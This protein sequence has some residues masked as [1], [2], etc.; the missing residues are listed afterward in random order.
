[1]NHKVRECPTARNKEMVERVKTQL[2]VSNDSR[3]K[4][5]NAQTLTIEEMETV[6]S[7][8]ELATTSTESVS[9]DEV[10]IHEIVFI[11]DRQKQKNISETS[12]ESSFLLPPNQNSQHKMGKNN[13]ILK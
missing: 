6:N 1:M 11:V 8:Q 2:Q 7:D 4:T 3:I 10:D 5:R 9:A 13:P 12:I